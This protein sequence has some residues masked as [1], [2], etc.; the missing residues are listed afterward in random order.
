MARGNGR[1][2]IVC[3][4]LDRRRHQEDLRKAAIRCCW[5]IYAFAIMS[6]H[7]RWDDWA[8]TDAKTRKKLEVLEEAL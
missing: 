7:L 2:D 3:D 8:A 1:Q 6:N 5:Q 4:D